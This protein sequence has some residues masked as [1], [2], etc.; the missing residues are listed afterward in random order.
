MAMPVMRGTLDVLILRAL[1]ASVKHGYELITWL[2]AQSEGRL[3]LQD[4][5]LYQAL[6]RLEERR[7][8]TAHWGVSEAN[9]R[10]RYYCITPAG[11]AWLRDETALWVSYSHL[12]TAILTGPVRG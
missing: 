3:D 9:R 5:A 1:M 8:V 4:S 10:A 11:R 2:E 7:H 6:H 12:V